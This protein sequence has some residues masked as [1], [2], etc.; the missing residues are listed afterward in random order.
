[1]AIDKAL[2]SRIQYGVASEE[3]IRELSADDLYAIKSDS[4]PQRRFT[5]AR[6]FG[7]STEDRTVRGV[8]HST[9]TRDRMGDVI[10][11]AGWNLDNY[12]ANPV[13]LYGHASHSESPINSFPVARGMRPRTGRSESG[14]RALL[15]DEKY[16]EEE[17]NPNAEL[18]WRMVAVGA[19]PGRSVGFLPIETHRPENDAEREKL[20]LG[21]WGVLYTKAELAESSVVPVPANADALQGKGFVE[22][23]YSAAR[24]TLRDV[25]AEGLLSWTDA[26]RFADWLPITDE[27]ADRQER[28]RKRSVVSMSLPEDP[29]P[30]PLPS[31]D[32]DLECVHC[33]SLRSE[34]SE[35]RQVIHE[36]TSSVGSLSR[37]IEGLRGARGADQPEHRSD[38]SESG[39]G[40]YDLLFAAIEERRIARAVLDRTVPRLRRSLLS[41]SGI[42]HGIEP[43]G[44]ARKG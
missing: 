11:V 22:R 36:L 32:E 33:A 10:R 15:I 35:A 21:Q 8:P 25:V 4:V 2:I 29:E 3:E 28:D 16:H 18:V 37:T 42:D 30:E 39:V 40:T 9:E 38:A 7:I 23:C 41:T 6:A 12:K 14:M 27:D 34:L 24:Q 1:M 31:D 17:T 19:L 43:Q 44:D 20:G 26:T 13:I 5:V